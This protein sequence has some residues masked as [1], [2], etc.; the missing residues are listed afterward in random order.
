MSELTVC[1]VCGAI[2]GN[3]IGQVIFTMRSD[4]CNICCKDMYADYDEP[5]TNNPE[6]EEYYGY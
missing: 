2:E 3:A 1:T 6:D 4:I 5:E